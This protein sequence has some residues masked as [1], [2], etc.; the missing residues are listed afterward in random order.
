M[1][2]NLGA[3]TELGPAALGVVLRFA[4]VFLVRRLEGA[5]TAHFFENTLGIK[6]VLQALEGAIDRLTFA[7]EYFWHLLI[8]SN[9]S[10]FSAQQAR[11]RK[12]CGV[13]GEAEPNRTALF[14]QIGARRRVRFPI[15]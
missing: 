3:E 11:L 7:N 9:P 6:L 5:Q 15:R 2:S 14:R 12:S 8:N 1:I 13:T 10:K 4:A